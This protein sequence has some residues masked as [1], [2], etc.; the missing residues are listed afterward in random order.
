[1]KSIGEVG[2]A[3][4]CMEAQTFHL[5]CDFLLCGFAIRNDKGLGKYSTSL[6]VL[7]VGKTYKRIGAVRKVVIVSFYAFKER[8]QVIV[9]I[10]EVVKFVNNKIAF[11]REIDFIFGTSVGECS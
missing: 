5:V 9:R 11:V 3:I 2:S 8:A 6:A 4:F 1:M 10:T 7:I